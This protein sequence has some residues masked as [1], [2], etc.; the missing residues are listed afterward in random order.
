MDKKKILI[1]T[2]GFYPQNNP[3]SFRATELAK[4]LAHQGHEVT[5]A[6]PKNAYDFT[7][8]ENRLKIK[9]KDMG[10]YIP[11]K[12]F[13]IYQN[14][15]NK[16]FYRIVDRF[17]QLTMEYPDIQLMFLVKKFLKSENDYD[18]LISIAAPH[19]IHWGVA[20]AQTK[21]HPIA[22]TWVA[23]CGDPFM[24][25]RLDS[26]RK[27]FYFKYVEKWFCRKADF[28]SVPADDHFH[29]YYPEFH[30]KI[31]VIPQGFKFEDSNLYKCKINNTTPTF[32][33]SG[34]FLPKLRDPRPFLDY[35][36]TLIENYKFVVFTRNNKFLE[37]YKNK[38]GNKLVDGGF[39]PRDK[40]LY[41]LSQMDFLVHIEFHDS[42]QSN[43]PSKLADYAIVKKPVISLNM[44]NID[45]QKFQAFL[46]KNYSQQL[47]LSG[48]EK[49][50]IENVVSAFISLLAND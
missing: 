43:S 22:K 11:Q 5:I 1:V 44:D 36:C 14:P 13:R 20:W 23:D 37:P 38:L 33:F 7:E 24:G 50:R 8:I 29:F 19:T 32:G 25:D 34:S 35:L 12:Y 3:R 9:I 2:A 16:F 31:R 41:E 39:I 10:F 18:L 30:S 42:V 17:L 48:A 49:F 21:K 45:K 46:N 40:L 26:F 15:I 28:I 4:E 6:L 47:D 27:F